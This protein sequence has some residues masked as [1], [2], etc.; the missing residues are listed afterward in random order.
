MPNFKKSKSLLILSL[1]AVLLLSTVLSACSGSVAAGSDIKMHPISKFPENIRQ[2]PV[3]VR[4]AYQFAVANPDLIQAVPCYCGCAPAGHES[5]YDCYVANVS[6]NGEV[7][8]DYHALGC[9]ICVDITLDVMRLTADGETIEDIRTV[10]DR[11]YSQ[12]GP[13]NMTPVE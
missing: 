11:T 7:L 5:N 9:T 6:E 13:T 3:N 2:A 12:Y 10:I 8:Y 4:E 1:A